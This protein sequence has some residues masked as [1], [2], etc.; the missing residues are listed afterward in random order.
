MVIAFAGGC[1][2]AAMRQVNVPTQAQLADIAKAPVFTGTID[3]GHLVK[4]YG[5]SHMGMWIEVVADNGG[6][7]EFYIRDS[8]VIVGADGKYM[9]WGNMRGEVGKKVEIRYSTI[10]DATGGLE[11]FEN[12]RNGVLAMRFLN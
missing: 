5:F 11:R 7:N 8:S 4:G 6:K 2:D 12:G 10:T 9:A 3:R 1:L